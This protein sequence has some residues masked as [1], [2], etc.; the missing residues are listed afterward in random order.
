[1]IMFVDPGTQGPHEMVAANP[2][3]TTDPS[4]V[5]TKVR[6]PEV[7]VTVPGRVVPV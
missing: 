4:D 3:E 5:K 1:M 6:H 7:A 2:V